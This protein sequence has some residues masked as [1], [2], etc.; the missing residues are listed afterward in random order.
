M[1]VWKIRK[2]MLMALIFEKLG[3]KF[4]Q[5]NKGTAM[6]HRSML[7]MKEEMTIEYIFR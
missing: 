4:K 7:N 1:S 2:D 6:V 5:F 3:N